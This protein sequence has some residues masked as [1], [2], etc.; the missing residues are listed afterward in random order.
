MKL[1]ASAS[2]LRSDEI[3]QDERGADHENS[4][5]VPHAPHGSDPSR[6]CN[7]AFAADNG[8]DRNHV[9]GVG[10]MPH[11]E[12][13]TQGNNREQA[14]H[15]FQRFVSDS[16]RCGAYKAALCGSPAS[17]TPKELSPK[18][19]YIPIMTSR[20]DGVQASSEIARQ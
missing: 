15:R 14:N 16:W 5:R 1:H 4:K 18:S 19:S 13:K 20:E 2:R 7:V 9:V 10:G 3:K 8:A 17:S 11:P 12:K 6:F